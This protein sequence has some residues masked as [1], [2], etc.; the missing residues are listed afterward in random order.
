MGGEQVPVAAVSN[1]NVDVREHLE[2]AG[3]KGG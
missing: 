1:L 3:P 2:V